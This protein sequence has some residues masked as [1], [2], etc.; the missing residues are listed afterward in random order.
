MDPNSTGA[1]LQETINIVPVNSYRG[2]RVRHVLN[3]AVDRKPLEELNYSYKG[4]LSGVDNPSE[5]N[6]VG[7]E[8]TYLKYMPDPCTKPQINNASTINYAQAPV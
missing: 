2:D 6:D 5:M 4:N 3:I 1:M 7:S 8:N